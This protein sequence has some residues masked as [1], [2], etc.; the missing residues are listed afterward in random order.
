MP[1]VPGK[2]RKAVSANI[3]ELVA[4]GRDR[5]QAIAISLAH[6]GLAKKKR[7]RKKCC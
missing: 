5:K 1:L 6:A 7:T 4:S 3:K 2:G